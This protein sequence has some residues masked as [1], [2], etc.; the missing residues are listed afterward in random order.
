[1]LK[2]KKLIIKRKVKGKGLYDKTVNFFLGNRGNKLYNNERHAILYDATDKKYKP[3]FFMGPN[4]NIFTRIRNGDDKKIFSKSDRSSMAH[5][6][7]YYLSN[8]IS[9]I[10]KADETMVNSL[11]NFEKDKID[12][13]WNTRLGRWGIQGKMLLEDK[14]PMFFK[15]ESFT[16]FGDYKN[17]NID[18]Q[19]LAKQKLS[20]LEKE[21]Y[22]K[23]KKKRKTKRKTIK[24][25]KI[26][27]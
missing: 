8:S 3:S 7:R 10:R 25:K 26:K 11:K 24:Q 22:G 13:K 2:N 20:E 19:N 21:G 14:L 17:D 12:S 6:L 9:D 4:T 1:M 15:P 18:N 27:H 23:R 5:D 16:S